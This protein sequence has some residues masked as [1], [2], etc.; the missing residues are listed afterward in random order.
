MARKTARKGLRRSGI[1][2]ELALQRWKWPRFSD[3]ARHHYWMADVAALFS[4]A[5]V[6]SFAVLLLAAVMVTGYRLAPERAKGTAVEAASSLGLNLLA[7]EGPSREGSYI[8]GS[9]SFH[10]QRLADGKVIEQVSF[11]PS[12][13]R[14]CWQ[15]LGASGWKDNGCINTRP[16]QY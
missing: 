5:L 13:E 11:L 12:D 9:E 1:C 3:R 7:F 10:W 15:Q 6:T 14:L 8:A 4:V 2:L 16:Y